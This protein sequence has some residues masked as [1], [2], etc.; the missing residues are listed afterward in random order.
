MSGTGG[1][2]GGGGGGGGFDASADCTGSTKMWIPELGVCSQVQG[3]TVEILPIGRGIAASK[4]VYS[5]VRSLWRARKA[6]AIVIGK[7]PEY[8]KAGQAIGAGTFDLGKDLWDDLARTKKGLA[9]AQKLNDVFI[10]MAVRMKWT[11]NVSSPASLATRG[12]GFRREIDLLESKGYVLSNN[13]T[14]M[15]RR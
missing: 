15:V 3:G 6:G 5:L 10:N 2:G 4:A 7:Y 1:D 9:F 13:G 12:S 11:V 8:V 14:K